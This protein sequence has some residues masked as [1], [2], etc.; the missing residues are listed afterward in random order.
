MDLN[1]KVMKVA[2]EIVDDTVSSKDEF[3]MFV[4]DELF[5]E[6]KYIGEWE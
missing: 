5:D 4:E 2:T 6:L 1:D 3:K